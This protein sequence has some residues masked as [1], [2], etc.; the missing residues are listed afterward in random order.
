MVNRISGEWVSQLYHNPYHVKSHDRWSPCL[1]QLDLS[2]LELLVEWRSSSSE[3]AWYIAGY[4]SDWTWTQPVQWKQQWSEVWSP[5]ELRKPSYALALRAH[6]QLHTS[7]RQIPG[8]SSAISPSTS[9]CWSWSSSSDSVM[10]SWR[11]Q[12]RRQQKFE[13]RWWLNESPRLAQM[14]RS[15]T[16]R[17][18]CAVS[19]CQQHTAA[20][21][22]IS[23]W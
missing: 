5:D 2:L 8:G 18:M 12:W 13:G 21:A 4:A 19:T 9:C 1:V 15:T 14:L 10:L 23:I 3:C 11:Q 7:Q 16:H 22:A 6:W 17:V 20:A